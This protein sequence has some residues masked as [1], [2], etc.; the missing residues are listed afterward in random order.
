MLRL[1]LIL[2]HVALLAG[3]AQADDLHVMTYEEFEYS[4]VHMDLEECPAILA[5]EGVFCRLTVANEMLHVF[6]FSTEGEQPL[7]AF[8]SFEE[9]DYDIVLN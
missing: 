6:A 2:A 4:V 1:S 7:V 9:E 3:I 8:R 5:S